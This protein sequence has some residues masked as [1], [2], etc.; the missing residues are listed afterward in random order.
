MRQRR[1][2]EAEIEAVLQSG[3][4]PFVDEKGNFIY[5]ANPNGRRV[6][7]VVDER[8]S[9]TLVITAAD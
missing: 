5:I 4:L 1:I 2:S 7:V 3:V 9:P 6:K 8:I